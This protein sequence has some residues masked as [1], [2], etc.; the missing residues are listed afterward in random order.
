MTRVSVMHEGFV[1]A[2]AS[3]KRTSPARL[4]IIFAVDVPSIQKLL[5]FLT[6]ESA[7]LDVAERMLVGIDEAM[8]RCYITGRSHA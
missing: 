7:G 4:A 6:I 5:L 8:T 3:A 1:V 2:S